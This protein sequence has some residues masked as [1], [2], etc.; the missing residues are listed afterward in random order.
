MALLSSVDVDVIVHD[1]NGSAFYDEYYQ[2]IAAQ[3]GAL[4][5]GLKKVVC[6]K[7]DHFLEVPIEVCVQR[8]A[9]REGTVGRE[10]IESTATH[11]EEVRGIE[12]R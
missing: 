6:E 11:M 3:V 8:D 9:L 12:F 7:I 10:V 2:Q 1:T 4:S 5:G